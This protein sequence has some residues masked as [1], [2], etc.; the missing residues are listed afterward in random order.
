[1]FTTT[2]KYNTQVYLLTKI[3]PNQYN[4]FIM[5]I[6]IRVGPIWHLLL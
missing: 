2:K 4:E 5:V 6:V 3:G 1:M